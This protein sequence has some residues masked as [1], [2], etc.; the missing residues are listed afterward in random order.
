MPSQEDDLDRL[1]RELPQEEDDVPFVPE[2]PQ[3]T[4]EDELQEPGTGYWQDVMEDSEDGDVRGIQDL[5]NKF[6]NNETI[7]DQTAGLDSSENGKGPA[8]RLRADIEE[9][10]EAES[11]VSDKKGK[12]LEKKRLKEEK[13]AAK[14]A[15]REAAKAQKEEKRRQKKSKKKGLE[16]EEAAPKENGNEKIAEYDL[17]AD[18]DLLDSIVSGAGQLFGKDISGLEDSSA[19]PDERPGVDKENSYGEGQKASNMESAAPDIIAVDMDEV[20]AYVPDISQEEGEE[21][22][23]K[24]K[25]LMTKFVNFLMEEEEET[26]NEDVKM[27]EENQE[28][29]DELDR[30]EE[31]ASKAK[32]SK[33]KKEKKKEQKKKEQKPK[34]V[35]PPKP[36]KA[37]KPKEPEP[38]F[39][40]K[41]LTFKRIL[42]VLL[43][44]ITV[45]AVIFIFVNLSVDYTSKK[46]AETA[47]AEGD[48][49]TCYLQLYGK[50][51]SESEKMMYGKS[52]SILYMQ[53]WYQQYNRIAR[54]GTA[55]EELDQLI[56]IVNDYPKLSEYALQWNAV[57]EIYE[58]YS[59]LVNILYERYGVT[60]EQAR[61][62]AAIRSDIAYTKAIL[63]LTEGGGYNG[64]NM[65]EAPPENPEGGLPEGELPEEGISGEQ[66]D[67]LPEES[68]IESGNFVDNESGQL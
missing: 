15:A 58:I 63:A 45:G 32:K 42:P 46:A 52:Q 25:G 27:S 53:L 22:K 50:K 26:E 33:K 62:I 57:P 1:L 64:E 21:E 35:K 67:I 8:D 41:K 54:E 38:Y 66:S 44:G 65:S 34:K 14:K 59:G 36:Q 6:D 16:S 51:L 47:F 2:V 31:K 17:M 68:E 7:D 61:E 28:I 9:G 11:A 5:L 18:K 24:K 10:E 43:L 30:E 4:E 13:A 3:I 37:K 55:A 39:P 60:E 56:Q 20:D 19:D 48:Y 12:N 40:G 29:L 49:R 23:P